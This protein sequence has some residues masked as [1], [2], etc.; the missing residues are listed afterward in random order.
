[1][2]KEVVTARRAEGIGSV[3]GRSGRGGTGGWLS[4]WWCGDGGDASIVVVK[5]VK[6][7]THRCWVRPIGAASFGDPVIMALDL[8][9]ALSYF[10]V[11]RF[12]AAHN[13]LE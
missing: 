13:E 3:A 6:L 12:N 9:Q 10:L 2:A 4:I 8:I 1:M 7:E 11:G 5:F